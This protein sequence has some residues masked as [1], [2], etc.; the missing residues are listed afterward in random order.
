MFPLIF[1]PFVFKFF[2]DRYIYIFIMK[3]LLPQAKE[4]EIAAKHIDLGNA[5]PLLGYAANLPT[6]VAVSVDAGTDQS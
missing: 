5:V 6:K 1:F 3:S 4:A 2:H